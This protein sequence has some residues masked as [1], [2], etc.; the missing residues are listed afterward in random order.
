VRFLAD[1]SCD[2]RVVRALRD[3]G[4]DVAAVVEESRGAPDHEVFARARQ[5]QRVLLAEDKDFGQLA[6]AAE[7]QAEGGGLLL[8]RCPEKSRADLPTA[9]TALVASW[10]SRLPGSVV[11]WTPT[12][13][14][15]RRTHGGGGT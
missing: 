9:I 15:V 4:H 5:E 14:R 2:Y 1:E 13:V 7:L 12:R 6:L 8:M 3:S 10:G 11:V